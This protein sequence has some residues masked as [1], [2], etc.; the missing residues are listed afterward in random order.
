MLEKTKPIN[1]GYPPY[2]QPKSFSLEQNAPSVVVAQSPAFAPN[3]D[4][5]T[6]ILDS[7]TYIYNT[8]LHNKNTKNFNALVKQ[9][10]LAQNFLSKPTPESSETHQQYLYNLNKK[11]ETSIAFYQ[12]QKSVV[13]ELDIS[14][15]VDRDYTPPS[16]VSQDKFY[17]YVGIDVLSPKTNIYTRYQVLMGCSKNGN[18]FYLVDGNHKKIPVIDPK[19]GIIAKTDSEAKKII[20]YM[21]GHNKIV[22]IVNYV[23]GKNVPVIKKTTKKVIDKRTNI[24]KFMNVLGDVTRSSYFNLVIKGDVGPEGRYSVGFSLNVE[25]LYDLLITKKLNFGDF[26]KR[27]CGL[28]IAISFDTIVDTQKIGKVTKEVKKTGAAKIDFVNILK[29]YYTTKNSYKYGDL[30]VDFA[31][32]GKFNP[33]KQEIGI[34][35]GPKLSYK[36]PGTKELISKF[37]FELKF[38]LIRMLPVSTLEGPIAVAGNLSLLGI[39]NLFQATDPTLAVEW[40]FPAATLNI[41]SKNWSA[42]F[43][44]P[45]I[46]LFEVSLP[47]MTKA[48]T[49]FMNQKLHFPTVN[50]APQIQLSS[51]LPSL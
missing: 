4:N 39:I 15:L 51:R 20:R 24:D 12:K 26:I 40:G 46:K 7:L 2:S 41:N 13:N 10:T 8:Y 30:S 36:I 37:L 5:A 19:T 47:E 29:A 16:K 27:A 1:N 18:G 33:S 38:W 43:N 45:G 42:N 48:T 31:V 25:E 11:V 35:L 23:D 17:G 28:G 44:F 21:L 22:P 32:S 6:L 14:P 34:G 9:S 3:K 50:P 49:K